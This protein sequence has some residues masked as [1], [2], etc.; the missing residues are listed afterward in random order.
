MAYL[1]KDFL[2]KIG[3]LELENIIM[4]LLNAD[5]N[6]KIYKIKK[7]KTPER[8][9]KNAGFDFFIPSNFNDKKELKIKSNE[10][11]IIS[12]GIKVKIPE[13]HAFVAFNKSGICAKLGLQ[14]GANVIDENY[15]GELHFHL[16][17]TTNN[18]VYIKSD[19]KIIQ[20]LLIPMNYAKIEEV[21]KEE[22][23][24]YCYKERGNK[25]F[26]STGI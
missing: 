11:I 13:N 5:Y 9:G 18:N 14:V 7:V 26:G 22:D 1:K 4:N 6:L 20:F 19:M 17:N 2:A 25:G 10:S 3:R 24:D 21:F 12:S 8:D 23:M 16:I 15:T